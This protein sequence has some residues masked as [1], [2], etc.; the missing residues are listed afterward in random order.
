[1]TTT[2]TILTGEGEMIE[3]GLSLRDA[4]AEVLTS[5][6]REFEVRADKDGG[7]TLW[8]RQQVANR[9]W[10]ATRFFSIKSDREAAEQEIFEAVVTSERFSGHNEAITD[11]QYR[12]MLAD[13]EEGE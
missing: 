5:D 7:F 4:A 11:E 12:Q 3:T 10:T 2:Y 9:P 6:S 8:T 13:L 1:M